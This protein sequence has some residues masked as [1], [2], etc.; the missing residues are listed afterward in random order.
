M[1]SRDCAPVLAGINTPSPHARCQE[2]DLLVCVDVVWAL[3]AVV[4]SGV[5]FG[6]IVTKVD[7][8]R[9]VVD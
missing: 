1:R 6:V 9:S 3:E 4:G 2:V 7:I 8:P 5:V